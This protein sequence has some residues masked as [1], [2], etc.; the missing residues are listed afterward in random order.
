MVRLRRV[1]LIPVRPDEGRLTEPTTDVQ[2]G[3]REPLFVPRAGRSLSRSGSGWRV[4]Q[5]AFAFSQLLTQRTH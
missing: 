2:L 1:S 5:R 3:R 4:G